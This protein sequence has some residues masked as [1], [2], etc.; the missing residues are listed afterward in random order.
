MSQN[1][2]TGAAFRDE[3]EGNCLRPYFIVTKDK[4]KDNGTYKQSWCRG[5]L[6]SRV[7]TILDAD[8]A[9]VLRGDGAAVRSDAE[10]D[11]FGAS[12]LFLPLRLIDSWY[13]ACDD[14]EHADLKQPEDTDYAR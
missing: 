5:C 9:A 12:S 11:T 8:R 2:P 13:S 10:A 6:K 1:H 7:N 4:F 3:P 14:A